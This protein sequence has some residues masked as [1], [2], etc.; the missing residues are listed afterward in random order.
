M[1]PTT[2]TTAAQPSAAQTA[3]A[4]AQESTQGSAALASDFETFLTML[5]VQMQ[6]QDPLNPTDSTEFASQLAQF[7]TVEQ[8]TLT[9]TLLTNLGSQLGAMGMG[10]LATWVGM[11][12][13][14]TAPAHFTGD[15]IEVVPNANDLAATATLIVRNESGSE[16]QRYA[17]DPKSE[18]V[19]WSGIDDSGNPFP[20]G[21]YTFVTE[22]RANGETLDSVY[23]DIYARVTEARNTDE[24]VVLISPGG[25]EFAADS[26]VSLREPTT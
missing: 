18:T 7:S 21:N 20:N 22:S 14:V 24:G 1:T 4:A 2:S 3:S 8:Q 5:S 9:N 6:N 25:V 17:I 13:R 26:V 11:E 19:T 12:A 23:G 16:V 15:P 10:N